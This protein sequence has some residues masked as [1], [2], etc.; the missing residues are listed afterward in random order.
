M[1]LDPPRI[2]QPLKMNVLGRESLSSDIMVV[3]SIFM[4]KLHDILCAYIVNAADTPSAIVTLTGPPIVG[5]VIILTCEDSHVGPE[6]VYSWLMNGTIVT[7]QM[8]N[9]FTRNLTMA[10]SGVYTCMASS[11]STNATSPGLELVVGETML[12]LSTVPV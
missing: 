7:G 9:T 12:Y 5:H 4:Y 8:G 10:D 1:I 11:G 3:S 6:P 2:G